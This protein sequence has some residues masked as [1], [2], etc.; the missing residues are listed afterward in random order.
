MKGLLRAIGFVA[1]VGAFIMLVIDGTTSIA[2]Q[3]PVTTSLAQLIDSVGRP[4]TLDSWSAATA[5]ALHPLVWS[6]VEWV[7]LMPPAVIVLALFGVLLMMLG[8]RRDPDL[9]LGREG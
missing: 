3:R 5:R 1:L 2:A 6:V 8:R 9:V 4:G 7:V